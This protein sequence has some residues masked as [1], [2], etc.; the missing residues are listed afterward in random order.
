MSRLNARELMDLLAKNLP[1]VDHRNEVI[2][3]IGTDFVRMRLPVLDAYL[4]QDLPAGS[5]QVVLS[6]PVMMGFADTALYA[7]VHAFYGAKVFAAIVNFNVS[8]FRVAGAGD[9]RAVA[10][11]LRK[12]ESLA[13]VEA[14][15]FSG[16]GEEPCAQIGATYAVR[17]AAAAR[18]RRGPNA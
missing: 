1:V 9:L 2:E 13:F 6:A 8:F 3:E 18:Q 5:G 17:D 10:R 16:V 12:G 4:S 7:C 15:L 11:L 14:R